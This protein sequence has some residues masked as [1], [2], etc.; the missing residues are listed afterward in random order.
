M[1][2]GSNGSN[3]V[4]CQHCQQLDLYQPR[5]YGTWRKREMCGWSLHRRR[6]RWYSILSLPSPL[7]GASYRSVLTRTTRDVKWITS[8]FEGIPKLIRST[9][10]SWTK[11]A[12]Q[13]W[14]WWRRRMVTCWSV[15]VV[16]LCHMV[17]IT[18]V[19]GSSRL[20]Q[21][22]CNQM[23]IHV[24]WLGC[25]KTHISNNVRGSS[26]SAVNAILVT[27]TVE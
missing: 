3:W 19:H 20:V 21:A 9:S 15:I 12:I 10:T 7:C 8:H 22:K 27:V 1:S 26:W 5:M 6:W 13:A 23:Y 14:A 18:P 24:L 11:Y 2:I 4:V 17:T 25:M 16:M